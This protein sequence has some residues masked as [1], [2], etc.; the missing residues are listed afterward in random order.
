MES[1]VTCQSRKTLQ[2]TAGLEE[3]QLCD[4]GV[5]MKADTLTFLGPEDGQDVVAD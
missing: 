2:V 1:Q 3:P 4:T 5:L